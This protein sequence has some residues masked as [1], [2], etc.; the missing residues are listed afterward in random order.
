MGAIGGHHTR[1]FLWC[2]GVL[3]QV[4]ELVIRTMFTDAA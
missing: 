4:G 3:L 1:A 2:Q